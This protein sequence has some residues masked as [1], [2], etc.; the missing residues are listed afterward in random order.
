MYAWTVLRV[1]ALAIGLLRYL[2]VFVPQA[3]TP[4]VWY[5]QV[6]TTWLLFKCTSIKSLA[7]SLVLAMGTQTLSLEPG[8]ESSSHDGSQQ[9]R[10]LLRRFGGACLEEYYRDGF[11]DMETLAL[12][13]EIIEAHVKVSGGVV[14]PLDDIP[15]VV[16]PETLPPWKQP[17]PN[18]PSAKGKGKD[19]GKEKGRGK[20]R[21]VDGVIVEDG[22]P[23][24]LARVASKGSLPG[25]GSESSSAEWPTLGKG[26][27][28]GKELSQ[29]GGKGVQRKGKGMVIPG[30]GSQWSAKGTIPPGS[31]WEQWSAKGPSK[32][33]MSLGKGAQAPASGWE[34]QG[35]GKGA[36]WSVT[37]M[38]LPV[39]GKQSKGS[40][41]GSLPTK[42]GLQKGSQVAGKGGK[43]SVKGSQLPGKGA[44]AYAKAHP[45]AALQKVNRP[46]GKF[47]KRAAAGSKVSKE[48][49]DLFLDADGLD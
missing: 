9:F 23:R 30:K 31:D 7:P 35:K 48:V 3:V 20:K 21:T 11:W 26:K 41:K 27:A 2:S 33:S 18:P 25:K 17:A 29:V 37:G 40:A 19:K 38:P 13:L 39:K 8:S 45:H 22:A 44:A 34:W 12:D 4:S 1:C 6:C 49:R 14:L 46:V 10:E 16:L 24:K 15:E 32:G 5:N 47:A 36:E 42:N 28:T 43:M